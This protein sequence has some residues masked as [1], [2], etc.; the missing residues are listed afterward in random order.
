MSRLGRMGLRLLPFSFGK[1]VIVETGIPVSVIVGRYRAGE[2][3]N[4]I[5]RDY[6]IP[7]D[8]VI[9]TVTRGHGAPRSATA[10]RGEK[11]GRIGTGKSVRYGPR[12]LKVTRLPPRTDLTQAGT[13]NRTGTISI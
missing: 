9:P 12:P 2:D 13:Q 7:T 8:H 3:P 4:A 5:A 6:S 10:K 11:W 1:P